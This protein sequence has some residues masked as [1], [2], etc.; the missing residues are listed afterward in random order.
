M[1]SEARIGRTLASYRH[2]V[3]VFHEEGEGSPGGKGA[4]VE[5]TGR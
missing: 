2:R 5:E 3:L 4:D 1:L